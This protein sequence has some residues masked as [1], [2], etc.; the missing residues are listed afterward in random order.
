ML[1]SIS[2]SFCCD[3]TLT[4]CLIGYNLDK[5]FNGL[6]IF[7]EE[8][9]YRCAGNFKKKSPISVVN[10]SNTNTVQ[11]DPFLFYQSGFIKWST[12]FV[13]I[14]CWF[15]ENGKGNKKGTILIYTLNGRVSNRSGHL[16]RIGMGYTE[17]ALYIFTNHCMCILPYCVTAHLTFT[18][19]SI[20]HLPVIYVYVTV[21]FPSYTYL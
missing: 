6:V 12:S 5:S 21:C 10:H 3:P 1:L 8:Q 11:N 20:L 2:D 7:N 14:S 13:G 15:G 4:D 16:T 19:V 18:S 9:K 17:S